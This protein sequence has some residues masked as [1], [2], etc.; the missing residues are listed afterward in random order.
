M[1]KKGIRDRAA[2]LAHGL[3]WFYALLLVFPLY[4]IIVSAFKDNLA[5][6]NSPLSPPSSLSVSHFVDA[7]QRV[8]LGRAL[9]NS[10]F[11]TVS[12][13]LLTLALAIPASYALARS[14]GRIAA[15]CERFF[16][17]GFLIP[18]F[19][20]LVPTVLLAIHLQLFQTRAFL[21]IFLPAGALPLSV[22]LLTQ[23]MRAIPSD[24]EESAV[25]DGAGRI[26]ILLRIYLPLTMP[27]IITIAILNFLSFWNEY[28]FALILGGPDPAVRTVQVALPNLVSQTNTEYGVLLAGALITMIP[29]YLV[30]I[31]LQRR[32]ESALLE[33][34]V[35][36]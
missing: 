17:L 35:K 25:M 24:L 14:R 19:A 31:L 4:F 20:A 11:I 30:Y 27:G 29:V 6:F 26:R 32:M 7:F 1:A 3:A 22:I 10:T 13:E 18:S 28:L 8:E 33:G 5:I 9:W 15:W 36:S 34:A 16:A 23:F 2:P 12:A 21:I